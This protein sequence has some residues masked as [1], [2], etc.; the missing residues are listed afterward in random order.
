MDRSGEEDNKN[1]VIHLVGKTEDSGRDYI[2]NYV[3]KEVGRTDRENDF[4]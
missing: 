1:Y 3:Q 4:M 2:C